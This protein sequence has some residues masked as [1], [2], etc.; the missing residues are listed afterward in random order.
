MRK[1]LFGV[2]TA[3]LLLVSASSASAVTCRYSDT[4]LLVVDNS[5]SIDIF[6]FSFGYRDVQ[7]VVIDIYTCSDGSMRTGGPGNIGD[8]QIR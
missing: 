6:G 3:T 7:C 4:I 5:W 1:K 2:L 8:C